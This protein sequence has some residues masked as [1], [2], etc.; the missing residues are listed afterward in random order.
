MDDTIDCPNCGN[1]ARPISPVASMREYLCDF[2]G[3]RFYARVDYIEDTGMSE[4]RLFR[5]LVDARGVDSLPKL[6]LKVERAFRGHE[7][8]RSSDL[9]VQVSSGV[10]RWDIGMYAERDL[11]GMME[12]AEKYQIRIQ[13]VLV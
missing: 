5:G 8:F 10:D 1:R 4:P 12:R 11:P 9:Q 6:R 7:R 13:F 2:C 3:N